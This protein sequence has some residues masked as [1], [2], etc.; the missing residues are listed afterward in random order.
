MGAIT[1]FAMKFNENHPHR[2]A[3]LIDYGVVIV[4][5]PS[6]VLGGFIG[7]Q[8]NSIAPDAFTMILLA[9]ILLY[10]SYKS[11]TKGIQL[12]NA[13]CQPKPGGKEALAPSPNQLSDMLDESE[14]S[15]DYDKLFE[16]K[17]EILS[18]NDPEEVELQNMYNP[19]PN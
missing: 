19:N 6:V 1:K 12:Y 13:D 15:D 3:S 8:I 7:V 2:K 9:S 11:V 17:K 14:S 18:E 4:M 10:L 5:L 16:S